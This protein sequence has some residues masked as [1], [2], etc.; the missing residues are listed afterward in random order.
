M[1]PIL[2]RWLS[3]TTCS[4]HWVGRSVLF[5]NTDHIVLKHNSHA[6]YCDR[7]TGTRTCRAYAELYRRADLQLDGRGRS[8][9]L[10]YGEGALKR[11]EGRVSRKTV[12]ADCAAMGVNFRESGSRIPGTGTRSPQ[13]NRQ[14][15]K[16]TD[17]GFPKSGNREVTG[18]PRE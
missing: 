16:S 6:S 18:P 2:D 9:N 14:Y 17:L 8:R 13:N 12:L 4:A 1:C 15:C 5:E 7:F 10:D 3:G 11:W